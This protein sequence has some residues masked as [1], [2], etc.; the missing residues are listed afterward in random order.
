[1]PDARI[2]ID[3]FHV[4]RMANNAVEKVR[5]ILRESLTLKQRRGLMHDRFVLLKRERELNDKEQLLLSGWTTNYPEL[6]KNDGADISTLA[7]LIEE[8]KL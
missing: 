1:M 2:V 4:V 8:G 5:K 7:M 3:K 6:E